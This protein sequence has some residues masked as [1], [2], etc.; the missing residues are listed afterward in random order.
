[1]EKL[2]FTEQKTSNKKIKTAEDM[3][4]SAMLAI[5]IFLCINSFFGL[6]YSIENGLSGNFSGGLVKTWNVIADSIG[7][8]DYIIL[9]KY[10]GAGESSGLFLTI[11]MLLLIVLTYFIVKA[12]K[13]LLLLVYIIPL[14]LIDL[15]FQL[16]LSGTCAV[17][18]CITSLFA[19]IHMK[20]ETD[21]L[22]NF[23]IILCVG[24]IVYGSMEF[25]N[26]DSNNH[27]PDFIKNGQEKL[28]EIY[29]DA[30]YGENPLGNGDL[31]KYKRETS[32][33]T[34]LTV[35]ME[36]PQS[37]YLRGFTGDVF[38]GNNWRSLSDA[39]YYSVKQQMDW[40]KEDGFIPEGQIGQTDSFTSENY[41]EGKISIEVKNADKSFAYMPYEIKEFKDGDM[42]QIKGGNY[43]AAEKYTR[44]NEYTY[45]AGDSV[46]QRWTHAVAKFYTEP[47]D[48]KELEQY[49]VDESHYNQYVYENFTYISDQHK[50][51]L[52]R[53]FSPEPDLEKNHVEYRLAIKKIKE[54]L[55]E[56]FIYTDVIEKTENTS[57]SAFEMFMSSGRGYDVHYATAAV[58]MFR[59]YGIPAR[60]VEGYLITPEDAEK[61]EAGKPF[62]ITKENAHAWAEIYIDG[63]GFVPI[64]VCPDEYVKMK[65]AD[66]N[67]GLSNSVLAEE[68]IT[69][70]RGIIENK[71]TSNGGQQKSHPDWKWLSALLIPLIL[72]II[73]LVY[74]FMKVFRKLI[75]GVKRR[76]LFLKGDPKE[77]VSAIYAYIEEKGYPLEN[78]VVE[79]GNKAAYSMQS[80]D[81]NERIFMIEALKK[82]K[83]QFRKNRKSGKSI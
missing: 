49:L 5:G 52:E 23:L 7:R 54:Y 67:V 53:E 55:D 1:M 77:A 76:R 6:N 45:V 4:V 25:I 68:F 66:I 63:A 8:S 51:I 36:K 73:L 14:M 16:K 31:T 26:A 44:L 39:A 80:I 38:T 65:Q 33:E 22:R 64:E 40:F 81:E 21:F 58:L 72:L 61:A 18:L 71:A 30:Y 50:R 79:T 74:L 28:E 35:V 15:L 13:P 19:V 57:K 17:F 78:H 29:T 69:N 10:A 62:D 43:A 2:A 60:Y 3:F 75:S 42:P 11:F 46:T 34:A 32:D 59:Y 37:V 41:E 9:T 83:Q 82:S 20:S 12:K 56:N 24:L 47:S 70:E 48:S 27:R